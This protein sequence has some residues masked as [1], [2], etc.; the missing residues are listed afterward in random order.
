MVVK[1]H[2]V[3]EIFKKA[4]NKSSQ[5][6]NFRGFRDSLNRIASDYFQDKLAEV[7]DDHQKI[8]SEI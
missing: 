4:A 2:R 7:Q 8:L 1:R 6:M 3:V 5:E